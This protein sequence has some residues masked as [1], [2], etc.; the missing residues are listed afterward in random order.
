MQAVNGVA[1]KRRGRV[2]GGQLHGR[3]RDTRRR[4]AGATGAARVARSLLLTCLLGTNAQALTLGSAS[5]KSYLNQPLDAEIPVIGMTPRQQEDLRVRVADPPHFE[6]LGIVYAPVVNDLRFDIA[7]DGA[8][9]IVRVRSDLPIS[10]PFLDFP[11][12]MTWPGGRLVKQYTLLLDPPTRVAP[13]RTSVRRTGAAVDAPARAGDVYGPVQRGETLWPIAESLRPAGIT[14]RQIAIALVRANPAAFIDGNVNGLRAGA[15]LTVPSREFIEQLGPADARAE[16]VAQTRRWQAPVATS[17]RPV[18]APGSGL[19]VTTPGP[20]PQA[21][22]PALDEATT[23]AAAD[24]EDARLRIVAEQAPDDVEPGSAEDLE[25]QLLATMEEIETNRITT[26]GLGDRLALLEAEMARVQALVE[27][28]DAEIAAL[29]AEV[30]A[31]EAARAAPPAGSE[32]SAAPAGAPAEA[33]PAEAAPSPETPRTATV[34]DAAEPAAVADTAAAASPVTVEAAV[35][36]APAPRVSAWLEQHRTA[37]WLGLALL[38]VFALSFLLRRTPAEAA[39]VAAPTA[40][41]DAPVMPIGGVPVA[42]MQVAGRADPV[43]AP[44][45]PTLPDA[46]AGDLERELEQALG[47]R[48]RTASAAAGEGQAT[49][50]PHND[51]IDDF[52]DE[53]VAAWVAEIERVQERGAADAPPPGTMDELPTILDELDDELG[54]AAGG[55]A[56][57]P[58][59]TDA[60]QGDT[61]AMSL[62]LARAYLEIGDEEGARDMLTQAL[63]RA[64][65]PVQRRQIEDLLAQI[66]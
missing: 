32:M 12:Q 49:P 47:R 1:A 66:D 57:A 20:E 56:V 31:R 40:A 54:A 10:E 13:A 59:P 25:Q 50:A 2:T 34:S 3:S 44:A 28:R 5:V 65:D 60:S 39:P 14:T 23:A 7:Q 9:W 8:R 21:T 19:P 45:A 51:F 30:E 46:R 48:A 64:T 15:T 53:D 55:R 6:R 26:D 29:Q 24:P 27:T 11:L 52:S 17:P 22:G 4:R 58:A 62:D 37:V 18:T 61:F 41:S 43:G 63:T 33:R 36:A 35:P 16:F 42:G 38:A